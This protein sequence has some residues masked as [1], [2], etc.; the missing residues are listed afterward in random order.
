M[1]DRKS[2]PDN[3]DDD[4][5]DNDDEGGNFNRSLWQWRNFVF[6][7]LRLFPRDSP[8]WHHFS[9]ER[10]LLFIGGS[11]LH[12]EAKRWKRD[13]ESEIK[14]TQSDGQR[15]KDEKGEHKKTSVCEREW[16]SEGKGER[17]KIAASIREWDKE[18]EIPKS[19]YNETGRRRLPVSGWIGHPSWNF[20]P[21]KSVLVHNTRR[22]APV[23][24]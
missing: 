9:D 2:T 16:D 6:H 11:L 13:R 23:V 8:P 20:S 21:D 5:D 15:Q 1:I 17:K 14:V 10:I 18:R 12:Y 3:D 4:D 19:W 22:T 24:R 7:F